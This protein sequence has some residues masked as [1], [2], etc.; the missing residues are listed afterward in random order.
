MAR[1]DGLKNYENLDLKDAKN[2]NRLT[3]VYRDWAKKYDYDND[4]VLGTVSQPK[5]VN[6][7]STRLKDKTAKIIDVGCGTGLVG[8]KLKA[9]DFIY[10]DGLDISKDMLSIAKSR[11]YRNLFLGS[12]NKQLPVLD[13]AYDAA[14]C[15]GVFTHGH[16]SSDGFNELCR[17]V[18]P[19]GYVCFTINE[20]VFEEYG[21][22]EMI[23]EFQ[24]NKVWEV[25]SLYKDD[26][27]TL[28]N[29]KG[30]YCLAVVQ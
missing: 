25:I 5:S 27:M 23:A 20:G 4:H 13:D 18:K 11:G 10:F 15:I 22:K 29:V 19:G 1:G 17:I 30:Y 3:E 2:D 6:L 8:E 14:M 16:V 28:E 21:F 26:Y 9:K 24:L 7:L 12:L